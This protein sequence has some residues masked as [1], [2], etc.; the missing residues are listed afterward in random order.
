MT[1][2]GRPHQRSMSAAPARRRVGGGAAGDELDPGDG[3]QR[4]GERGE[5]LDVEPSVRPGPAGDALAERLGLLVDLLEHEV[6]EAALLGGLGG[7]RHLGDDA[8]PRLAGDAAD[9]D[10]SRPQVDDVAFLEEDDPAG[11]GEDR[12]DVGGE[13]RLAVADAH[14]KGYVLAGPDEAIGLAHVHDRDGV[15]AAGAGK[16]RAHGV[17]QV[18]GVGLLDEVGQRLGVGLRGEPV[19]PCLQPVAELPEVLDDPVVDHGDLAGAVDVGMGVQVIRAA[20]GRPARVGEADAGVRRPVLHR[21]GEVGELAHLLLDE[22]VAGLGDERDPGRVVATVLEPAKTL[23][24]D[25]PRG[26]RTRVPDDSAHATAARLPAP[27]GA[28]R[29]PIRGR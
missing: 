2:A 14:D 29:R 4:V 17:E 26:P 21:R 23:E 18:P 28:R 13:E 19:P 7:P 8:L 20:V 6:R 27:A 22:K 16:R 9:A 25:R 12:R 3:T 1:R 10:P 5:L 15:G 11:M 24:E